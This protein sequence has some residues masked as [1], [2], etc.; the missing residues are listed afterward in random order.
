MRKADLRGAKLRG[1]DLSR[2]DLSEAVLGN[3]GISIGI[4]SV[5]GGDL[6]GALLGRFDPIDADLGGAVLDD[7]NLT[8]AKVTT[9][10]LGECK[11]LE[12]ATMPDGQKYEDWLKD[13][14][15]HS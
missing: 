6:G 11:S 15:D 14:E 3:V 2:A 5:V 9:R 1:A 8:G 4:L 12:G 13:K 7:A 10:Q